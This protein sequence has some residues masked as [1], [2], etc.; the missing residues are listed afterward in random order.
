MDEIERLQL[1]T[2]RSHWKARLG[3][4]SGTYCRRGADNFYCHPLISKAFGAL[5]ASWLACVMG[6]E[7]FTAFPL[8]LG[9]R[10]PFQPSRNCGH[11]KSHR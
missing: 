6:I 1:T 3:P 8:P 9:D 7:R 10:R 4:R 11:P 5:Y 2:A